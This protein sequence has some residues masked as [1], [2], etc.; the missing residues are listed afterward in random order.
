MRSQLVRFGLAQEKTQREK[1]NQQKTKAADQKV[2]GAKNDGATKEMERVRFVFKHNSSICEPFALRA[3]GYQRMK[4]ESTTEGVGS[5]RGDMRELSFFQ[6]TSILAAILSVA[7]IFVFFWKKKFAPRSPTR[8]AWHVLIRRLTTARHLTH[9][10]TV[11]M[12]SM[13]MRLTDV[14][15]VLP[16]HG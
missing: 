15:E 16:F 10:T 2:Q 9:A 11:I 1:T 3:S 13:A 14:K 5:G 6:V 7:I 8:R 4:N 12:T